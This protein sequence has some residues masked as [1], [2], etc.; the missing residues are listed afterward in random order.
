MR[1]SAD[2]SFFF[3]PFCSFS[4]SP[5]LKQSHGSGV[6]DGKESQ[7]SARGGNFS[8]RSIAMIPTRW[9]KHRCFSL[10]VL[11]HSAPD[12]WHNLRSVWPGG[13]TKTA[14]G[15]KGGSPGNQK[16]RMLAFQRMYFLLLP[17]NRILFILHLSNTLS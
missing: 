2:I 10:S 13:L 6:R 15:L 3:F 5:A 12:Y 7:N 14:G 16:E 1:K 11:Y 4:H 17:L 9:L 8:L